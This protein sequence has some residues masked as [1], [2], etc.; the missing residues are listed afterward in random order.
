M[1]GMNHD[2]SAM[3]S[4]EDQSDSSQ[5]MPCD[6]EHCFTHALPTQTS[7]GTDSVLVVALPA[8]PNVIGFTFEN[9]A[10]TP[11]ST[12][13]PGQFIHVKTIVLRY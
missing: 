5:G 2:M 13:P 1:P 10:P 9:E 11:T 8:T 12:A 4:D 3:A 6:G 7:L